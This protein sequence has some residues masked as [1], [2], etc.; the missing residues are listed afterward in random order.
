MLYGE[1]FQALI[2]TITKWREMANH[3]MLL[4][5]TKET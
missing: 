2:D 4:T 1:P 5:I 3:L